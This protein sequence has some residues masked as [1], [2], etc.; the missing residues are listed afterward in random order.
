MA[1]NFYRQSGGEDKC[2]AAESNLLRGKGHDL[3]TYTVHNDAISH[4]SG[5]KAA[6]VSIWNRDSY[7]ELSLLIRTENPNIVHFHNTFPLMSPA[8]LWAAKSRGCAVVSTLH[9]YRIFCPA[10]TLVRN[11][12]IC[13][14]CVT[15]TLPWPGMAH[16]CYRDSRLASTAVASTLLVHKLLRTWSD[17]VDAF[18]ALT[19]FARRKFIK[20]GVPAEK[21]V[22]K[23]NFVDPDPGPAESGQNYALFVG[24]LSP[25]KGIDTLLDAWRALSG[26]IPLRIVGTGPLA[27]QVEA[28]ASQTDGIEFLGKMP[29]SKVM[30]LMAG[31]EFLVMPSLWYET[32]GLVIVEAFAHAKPVIASR[33]GAMTELVQEGHS[34]LHFDPGDPKDLAAKVTWAVD[35]PSQMRKMGQNAR[36]VYEERYSAERNYERLMEI[37]QFALASARGAGRR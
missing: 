21:I 9:N 33:L 30:D 8:A 26:K 2:F 25:E 28:V 22:L 17:K 31:A 7:R 29:A 16:G 27:P 36:N 1:H 15:R 11:G 5:L 13:E 32:F 14:D 4:M 37:Y 20:G 34:G 35:H 24:R 18:I 12:R 10:G 6:S 19:E 3:L 23:P